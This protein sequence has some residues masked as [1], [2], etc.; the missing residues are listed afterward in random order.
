MADYSNRQRKP[1]SQGEF[2]CLLEKLEHSI[3]QALKSQLFLVAPVLSL[4]FA[5]IP[6][7]GL[8]S[9]PHAPRGVLSA[10]CERVC[11]FAF[12]SEASTWTALC[13]LCGSSHN[14]LQFYGHLPIILL[15]TF[16]SFTCPVPS[17]LLTNIAFI[18][19]WHLAKSPFPCTAAIQTIH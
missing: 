13:S 8:I 4:H 16:S 9:A 2:P 17:G 5:P 7:L 12:L 3:F 11:L 19:L 1:T 10:E 14:C 15:Q 6:L 18:C